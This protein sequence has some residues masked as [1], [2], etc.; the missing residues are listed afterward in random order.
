[1]LSK[2]YNSSGQPLSSSEWLKD[3]HKA[4]LIDRKKFVKKILK[5]YKPKRIID[6][7]CATGLWLDLFDEFVAKDCE[8]IGVDTDSNSIK[9]A[10]IKS[11]SW[12]RKSK[13][14]VCD[15]LNEAEKIPNGDL[16]L[17]FNI[18]SYI[19]NAKLFIKTIQSKMNIN[20]KLVIRQY[21]GNTI[22]FGPMNS[23]D[24]LSMNN[25]LYSA[26]GTSQQF[27]HYDLDRIYS[28]INDSSF[29]EKNINFE[30]FQRN[31]PF[32]NEFINYFQG[33]LEWYIYYL[34]EYDSEKLQKWY[35]LSKKQTDTYFLEVDL[36]AELS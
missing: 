1:M 11:K 36:T 12:D 17:A 31:A 5:N 33:T 18:F 7:G 15:I 4:K 30:T 2:W 25:S 34:S 23:E 22:R 29:S 27:H 9:E 24:R 6:L 20:S 26:I 21:D 13:F 10:E 19:P 28:I 32:P 3:H 8:F 16:F 35:E 14:I